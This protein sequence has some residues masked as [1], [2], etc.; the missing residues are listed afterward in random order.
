MAF[1]FTRQTDEG[2]AQAVD[3]RTPRIDLV[4][5]ASHKRAEVRAAVAARRD[6]PLATM[7]ALVHDREGDVL[8]A[9]A[10]NPS[11]PQVVLEALAAHRK[12]AVRVLAVRRLRYMGL[13]A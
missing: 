1:T 6:C 7:L 8:E 12:D 10:I 5:L 2:L 11:V 9:L 13:A 4:H 3:P